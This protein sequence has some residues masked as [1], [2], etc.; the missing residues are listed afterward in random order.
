MSEDFKKKLCSYIYNNFRS[1]YNSN[2]E[3]ADAANINEK[4][5]RLIQMGE[6]NL[7]L[8][9]FKQICDSQNIKMS[10]VLKNIGE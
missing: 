10:T 3:F 7:T 2:R 4:V 9:K 1:K 5:V 8:N 6:Y